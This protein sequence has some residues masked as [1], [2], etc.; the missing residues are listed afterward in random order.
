VPFNYDVG[1]DRALRVWKAAALEPISLHECRQT[2]VTM[3]HEAGFALEEIG[4][5]VGHNSAYM[6]DRY[7]HLR[8][9]S[10][11]ASRRAL[12]PLPNW[13]RNWRIR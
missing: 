7:R 4:D 3:M 9:R 12:R 2:Y 5:Y 13:R 1:Y 8:E 11:G 10:R 6:T